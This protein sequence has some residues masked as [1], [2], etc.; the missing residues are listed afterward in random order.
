[1]LRRI[2]SSLGLRE[3]EG[4]RSARLFAFIFLLTAAAVLAKSAQR[5]IFLAAYPRTAIPDAF[6]LSA[7]VL[8]L[9]SIFISTLAE[10]LGLRRLMQGMLAAGGLL[11]VGGR[12]A[13]EYLPRQ[14]PMGVYVAVE[15][16]I[17]LLI[18]QGW[19]VASEAVNVRSA[20][21]LLPIVGLGAG[22]AWTVGGLAIGALARV[23]GPTT[24]L[25]LSPL[26][27]A[28][29]SVLLRVVW[30]LD[31]TEE[32]TTAPAEEGLWRSLTGGLR[33]IV[34]EPL[35]RVLAVIITVELVVEK[36]TDLQ[37]LSVAQERFAGQSGGIASFMGLFYGLTGAITLVAPIVTARVL[38]R[39]GS[40]RAMM[41]AQL[42][43]LGATLLFLF[44]PL[45][46][47]VVLLAG[48]DRV[49]KQSLGGPARSQV[50]GAVPAVRRAQ[51][52]ALLRGVLAAVFAALAAVALKALPATVP[53]HWLSA[54]SAGLMLCLVLLTGRHLR[55]SYLVALQRS[56]DRTRLDLDGARETTELDS[57]QMATL[58]LELGSGDEG[59][60]S[61]AV[62]ILGAADIKVARPLLRKALG[63]PSPEVRAGS[64]LAFGR[65][66]APQDAEALSK[67]LTLSPEEEVRCACLKALAE[68]GAVEA[69]EGIVPLCEDPSPRVR[70]LARASRARLLE[71]GGGA[72]KGAGAELV[73]FES[74]LASKVPQEREAAA[75]AMG[76]VPL[77]Q[78]RLRAGFTPLLADS[79]LLVR[80]AALGASGQFHDE[81]IVRALV[82]AL[83]EPTTSSAAFDAFAQLGD[84]GVGQVAHV[85]Q[86]APAAIVSR[87]ASA[88]SRGVG[89]RATELL[90]GM[91][92]HEDPQV[93]YRASRALV[94]RRRGPSWRPPGE[95]LLLRAIQAEL[96]QG[97]RYYAA[98]A[99]VAADVGSS[100][101][102]RRFVAG[103]IESRIQETERRL[104]SLVAVVADPRIARLSHHLRDASP[105]VTARVL[106]LVEQSLDVRLSSLVVPFLERLPPE[107][108]AAIG[109]DGFQVPARFST[110]A[111]GALVEM[112]DAHLQRCALLAFG[113]RMSDRFP[114]LRNQEEP[115]LRL[116]ERLR[117]LRSVPVFKD[118]TPEDLMKLA[119]I[120]SPVEHPARKV[121][122]KKG[123]PGDVLCVVV[124][125]KVEIRDSGQ[126]IAT[127]G[128]HDFFGELALFDQDP[129][130]ADAVCVEDTELLEIGGADLESLMERHRRRSATDP[131]AAD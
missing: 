79:S 36:V 51:A 70:A 118:L 84:A 59:R 16:M 113:E 93:R 111:V 75:W 35:M 11:L 102:E 130:S 47:V 128:P 90:T 18:T 125:G 124:K 94:L 29:A 65:G 99:G 6:L 39:F 4:S 117:F 37:L 85:L 74:M 45:F 24:L 66:G 105:Q 97:Y 112:G 63:H 13:M 127:Q 103:E 83:E 50:F 23:V 41:T 48:G 61:L 69:A 95:D 33:Y 71:Q 80:R 64:A 10:R 104:L 131:L 91:L 27:L 72:G 122:F 98:L 81:V 32:R 2:G 87:T 121:I 44:F 31:I 106:E 46:A 5:E 9:A 96:T 123:D 62:S 17:S 49:L 54:G 52:G 38:S 116:V 40:T 73:A 108:R 82:F 114:E 110:D 101:A 34:S 89:A 107:Q 109:A 60:A 21:R 57:E 1:M 129:R 55:K 56:V 19:A 100:D 67:A 12:L 120:A 86:K 26:L 3:G 30:R 22:I 8:C 25:V 119:E 58:G 76:Q 126:V 43:V 53:V 78:T 92:D 42:W 15:V 115:L 28:L 77:G 68:L 14:A 20:K 7:A 88:L